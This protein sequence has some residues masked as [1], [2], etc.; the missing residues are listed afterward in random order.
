M[1][2]RISY[3]ADGGEIGWFDRDKATLIAEDVTQWDG[4][5]RV[6]R[7]TGS[8]WVREDLYETA[9]GIWLI[10]QE[11]RDSRGGAVPGVSWFPVTPERAQQWLRRQD[12]HEV[13]DQHFEPTDEHNPGGLI[14]YEAYL[15]LL[16]HASSVVRADIES[17]LSDEGGD[18]DDDTNDA[19]HDAL[20]SAKTA[21]ALLGYLVGTYVPPSGTLIDSIVK[22]AG[23]RSSLGV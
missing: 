8:Q 14:S 9:G 11:N 15:R 1:T 12:L 20:A 21:E 16:A 10:Q 5:N 6:S 19:L 4:N 22:R 13:A 23:L 7:A 18:I 17:Q 3:T 2:T